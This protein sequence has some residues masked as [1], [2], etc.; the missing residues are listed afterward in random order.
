MGTNIK[1]GKG[2]RELLKNSVDSSKELSLT[3]VKNYLTDIFINRA[4]IEYNLSEYPKRYMWE[5]NGVSYSMWMLAPG[6][7]TG[8]AG[9]ALYMKRLENYAKSTSTRSGKRIKTVTR[10][11]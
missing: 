7:S 3:D 5:E 6:I 2:F 4:P 1:V 10:K 11:S 9:Y 8:D